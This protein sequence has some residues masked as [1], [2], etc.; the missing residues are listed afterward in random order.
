MASCQCCSARARVCAPPVITRTKASYSPLIPSP[1]QIIG[2]KRHPAVHSP[3]PLASRRNQRGHIPQETHF[4]FGAKP[5]FLLRQ[6]R[7]SADHLICELIQKAICLSEPGTKKDAGIAIRASK[8]SPV[9]LL[10]V[11]DSLILLAAA[12][13][14]K[15]PAG[16]NLQPSISGE[17]PG[18]S[19]S[20]NE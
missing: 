6:I 18:A 8:L 10:G 11:Q 1:L 5:N 14:R 12:G 16:E 19:Q 15:W 17:A 20:Y 3:T 4:Y 2:R 9:G 13:G 7:Y